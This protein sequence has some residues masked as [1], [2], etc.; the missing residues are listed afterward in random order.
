MKRLLNVIVLALAVNFLIVAA[1]VGY[2]RFNGS[3]DRGKVMA[4]RDVLFPPPAPEQPTTQPAEATTRPTL[5]LEELLAQQSGRAAGEQVEFIQHTFDAQMA[6][7]D[8]RQRELTDLQRQIDLAKE[9][10]ARDRDAL[11]E[12]RK[13]V[14]NREQ[15]ATK[16]E[17][18]KGFQDCL[19]L[20]RSIPGKQ[21][22]TIFLSL[23]QQTVAQYLQAMEARTAGRIIKEFKSPEETQFIQ[24]V[25]ERIR[26]PTTAPAPAQQQP[27]PTQA[28]AG[29]P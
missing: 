11:D 3:L 22:K 12:Q 18:D 8:R 28:S 24:K 4:I 17:T 10:I 2:L 25:L 6:Q 13:V 1:G 26:Q 14:D 16:L 21:V 15:Q 20:Y 19:A 23:D 29:A 7:L 27:A 9:Q 5:K